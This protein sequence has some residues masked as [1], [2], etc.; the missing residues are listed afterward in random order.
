LQ[1]TDFS[2]ERNQLLHYFISFGLLVNLEE[3]T[4]VYNVSRHFKFFM[5]WEKKSKDIRVDKKSRVVCLSISFFESSLI[6]Q[7][8][9]VLLCR[10]FLA[11]VNG[12]R[13]E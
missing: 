10:C 5:Q 7:F 13:V 9:V 3:L 1:N 4:N 12:L 2:C 8:I 11:A 6:F